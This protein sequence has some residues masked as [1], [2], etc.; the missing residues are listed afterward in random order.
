MLKNTCERL[1]SL[2]ASPDPIAGI[3]SPIAS[4]IY[5]IQVEKNCIEQL[6]L[7]QSARRR[8]KVVVHKNQ[9]MLLFLLLAHLAF[10]WA[11]SCDNIISYYST[12]SEY[13]LA[14]MTERQRVGNV[15]LSLVDAVYSDAGYFVEGT[16]IQTSCFLTWTV[17]GALP[18]LDETLQSIITPVTVFSYRENKEIE[19]GNALSEFSV[20]GV[21]RG[22]N[23]IAYPACSNEGCKIYTLNTVNEPPSAVPIDFKQIT[24]IS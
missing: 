10:I 7:H 19:A 6:K 2:S 11:Q 9:T 22:L 5:K 21:V 3:T 16:A 14:W 12:S 24:A 4:Y 18:S 15:Q 23:S 13:R 1:K 20:A 8:H 17:F